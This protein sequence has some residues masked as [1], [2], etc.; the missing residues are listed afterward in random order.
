MYKGFIRNFNLVEKE[1]LK[2]SPNKSNLQLVKNFVVVS[3][4]FVV[5][6]EQLYTRKELMSKLLYFKN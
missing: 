6:L 2:D 5:M 1:N 3:K 4:T